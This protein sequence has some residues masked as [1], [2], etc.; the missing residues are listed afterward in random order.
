[1]LEMPTKIT[2]IGGSAASLAYGYERA[3]QDID[4]LDALSADVER[5]VKAACEVTGLDLPV[6]QASVW[7]GPYEYEERLQ[8]LSIDG[9]KMLTVLVPEVH[10]LVLMKLVRAY[11]HDL[12]TM[13]AINSRVGLDFDTLVERYISEM[14]QAIGNPRNLDMNFLAGIERTF[15]DQVDNAETRIAKK[16]KES[17]N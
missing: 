7:D 12:E 2:V 9:L 16:R 11:E 13:V 14:G 10:D 3:T 15:P 1:M 5:A 8:V 17:A 4:T 6:K